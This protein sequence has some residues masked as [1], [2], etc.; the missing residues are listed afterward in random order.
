MG[1][2]G[3]AKEKFEERIYRIRKWI[4]EENLDGFFIYNEEFRPSHNLYISDYMPVQNIE[5][6][7]NVIYLNQESVILFLGKPM[8]KWQNL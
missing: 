1:Y 6:S 2:T 8:G 3:I 7:P 5:F 4:T